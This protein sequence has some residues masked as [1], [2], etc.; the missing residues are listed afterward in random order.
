VLGIFVEPALLF[1]FCLVELIDF[2]LGRAKQ[3][4]ETDEHLLELIPETTIQNT[5]KLPEEKKS[6]IICLS[7]YE[8]GENILTLS[9]THSFHTNCIRD[10]LNSHNNCPICK[11]EIKKE[12]YQP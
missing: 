2:W 11:H 7:D 6:C 9:C 5:E 8:V 10:W 12:D 3:D 1:N 4:Q